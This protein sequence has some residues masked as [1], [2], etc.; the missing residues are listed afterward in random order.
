MFTTSNLHQI[1]RVADDYDYH[2]Q[3]YVNYC[4]FL[5]QIQPTPNINDFLYQI[6]V[7]FSNE[8]LQR[9]QNRQLAESSGNN[10]IQNNQASS[11]RHSQGNQ[12]LAQNNQTHSLGHHG[13]NP[14]I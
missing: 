13:S 4:N 7:H 5:N 1:N 12:A 6:A 8:R 14:G 3:N 11:G 10:Q 9:M 2:Y